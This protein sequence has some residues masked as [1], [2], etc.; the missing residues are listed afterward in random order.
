MYE[1]LFVHYYRWLRRWQGEGSSAEGS[2]CVLLLML[3]ALNL[4]VVVDVLWR[5]GHHPGPPP[6]SR[7]LSVTW[8]GIVVGT[9]AYCWYFVSYVSR[10][11]ERLDD[12]LE[13]AEDRSSSSGTGPVAYLLLSIAGYALSLCF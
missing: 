11:R 8:P 13:D 9:V 10:E 3:H 4:V 7:L 1:N 5:V 12:P 2:A 6:F